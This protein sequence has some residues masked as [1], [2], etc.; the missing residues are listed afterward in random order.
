MRKT[1][2]VKIKPDAAMLFNPCPIHGN[3]YL[4]KEDK[5]VFCF[6][7]TKMDIIDR[8]FYHVSKRK[9]KVKRRKIL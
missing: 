3:K 5:S 6:A 8:C 1:K 9:L 2:L 7:K 4:V